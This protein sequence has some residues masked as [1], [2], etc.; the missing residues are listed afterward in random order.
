MKERP[1]CQRTGHFGPVNVGVPL[2]PHSDLCQTLL[3]RLELRANGDIMPSD[4]RRVTVDLHKSLLKRESVY[5]S[6]YRLAAARSLRSS[7]A[8]RR[9]P[10]P[11]VSR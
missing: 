1:D 8:V 5:W 11:G 9:G 3:H 6:A 7:S 2:R 4:D 10:Y